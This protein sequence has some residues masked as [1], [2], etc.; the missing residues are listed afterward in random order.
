MMARRASGREADAFMG[1]SV[2]GPRW[3]GSATAKLV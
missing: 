1:S 2:A 3:S